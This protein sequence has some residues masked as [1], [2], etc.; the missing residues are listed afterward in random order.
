MPYEK[1]REKV[2]EAVKKFSDSRTWIRLA[3]AGIETMTF[4]A[5]MDKITEACS[6]RLLSKQCE[7]RFIENEE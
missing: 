2:F 7:R 1:L 5:M 6:M 4:E 3:E